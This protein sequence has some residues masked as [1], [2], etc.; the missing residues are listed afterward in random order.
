MIRSL[1]TQLRDRL[2]E[3]LARLHFDGPMRRRT[4]RKLAAQ[5]RYDVNLEYALTVMQE[6]YAER[7]SGL[8]KVFERILFG[9][10]RGY[11]LDMAL[12]G[13]APPEE[14][15]LIRGGYRSGRLAECL[16]LCSDLIE[17]RQGIVGAVIGAVSYPF[18]LLAMLAV[19]LVVLATH[20]V[21]TLTLIV[22]PAT[23]TG[24]AAALHRVSLVVA[25][26]LGAGLAALV[27][28][29]LI[30][31][32][33]TLSVWKGRLRLHVEELPPW[34]IYRLVT[35]TLWLFA[36]ATLLRADIPLVQILD[37]MLAGNI[38]PWLRER[39]EA[40]R[41]QYAQGKNLGRVLVDT[42]LRFPDGEM[43]DDLL[44]YS[45]LPDFHS[46]LHRL[47]REWLDSGTRR[48]KEQ[49]GVL[50][51]VLLVGILGLMCCVAVA[52]VSVQQQLSTNMGGL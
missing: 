15:M 2:D 32:L 30:V 37:D 50:N 9:L 48:V 38:S 3:L 21:P 6:R 27:L 41:A 12:A 40:I 45:T 7:K 5:L 25:S 49:A 34:S 26:P 43:V 42:G 47:A 1:Q 20:V 33:S 19:V 4:W 23:F 14:L 11:S 46:L 51:T 29:L 22:D 24:A 13:L 52:V 10:R 31:V 17:A 35:G 16:D 36:V 39:V 44:I 18:L 8:A 28:I